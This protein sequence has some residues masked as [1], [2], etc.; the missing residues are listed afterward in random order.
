MLGDYTSDDYDDALAECED[1]LRSSYDY[2][3]DIPAP[4]SRHYE[5][6]SVAKQMSD[7]TWVGWTFWYGG[8]KHGE[9]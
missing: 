1:E 4:S 2:V 7:G 5:A 8:G 3:T 6:K 9:P